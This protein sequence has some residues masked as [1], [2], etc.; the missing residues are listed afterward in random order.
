MSVKRT[1]DAVRSAITQILD[2]PSP[3]KGANDLVNNGYART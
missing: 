2:T 1:R 3:A